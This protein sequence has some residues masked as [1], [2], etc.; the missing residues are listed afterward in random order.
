MT[1]RSAVS[2]VAT[3]AAAATAAAQV[4]PS[5]APSTR[6]GRAAVVVRSPQGAITPAAGPVAVPYT[7]SATNHL[8]VRLKIN[9]H[10]PYNF[11]VDTGAPTLLVDEGIAK[12]IGLKLEPTTRP[13][14]GAT[15][16]H[17]TTRP[18]G[19]G[20][21]MID[22]LDIDGGLSVAGVKCLVLTP[23]QIEGMNAVGVAG[24]D[25]HGLMG[26]S[27]LAR[28]KMDIDL[29]KHVMLWTPQPA[30]YVPPPLVRPAKP[31]EPDEADGREE[32]LESMGGVLRVLGPLVKSQMPGPP[33]PRGSVGVELAADAATGRPVVAVVLAGS[34][35]ARAGVRAADAVVAVNGRPV[36]TVAEVERATAK[37]LPGAAVTLK[38]QR[39]SDP[40]ELTVTAGEGL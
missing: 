21:A 34:P 17:A 8:V 36:H 38:L 14:T 40:V 9:G 31:D 32:R 12:Q 10:G 3:L 24:M 23:Y 5:T 18:A 27:V 4:G 16:G 25:L 30:D 22:R 35:A 2:I 37:V 39:G 7:L 1:R 20:W 11:I 6:P 33:R 19:Q 28:F 13:A 29:S 26:Y 15:T